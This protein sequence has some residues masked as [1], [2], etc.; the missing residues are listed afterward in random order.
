MRKTHAIFALGMLG[1]LSSCTTVSVKDIPSAAA[2]P[3][4]SLEEISDDDRVAADPAGSYRIDLPA[5][6]R[7][8]AGRNLELARSVEKVNLAAA[9][10]DQAQLSI[11]PDLAAGASFAR[12]NGLLQEI[13]GAPIETERV[14]RS[15]G[16]GTSTP[17][18]GVGIDL[19]LS[20]AIFDPLAA[21]QDKKAA[22]AFT[23]TT[24]A[25]A[26]FATATARF[27]L[28]A[29][30]LVEIASSTSPLR[31]SASTCLENTWLKS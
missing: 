2:T 4:R 24:V 17:V 23:A 21:K 29:L 1:A 6:L 9:K 12:Q 31:P 11:V 19:N 10:S 14:N 13:G 3:A 18:P 5:T 20:K 16:F 15:A 28:T 8:A 7:L 25:T 22:T 30:P 27:T 26:A